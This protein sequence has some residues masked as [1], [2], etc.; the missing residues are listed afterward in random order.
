MAGGG[1]REQMGGRATTP[2][3]ILHSVW[4][5]NAASRWPGGPAA[6]PA[7]CPSCPSFSRFFDSR[8]SPSRPGLVT[9]ERGWIGHG[10]DREMRQRLRDSGNII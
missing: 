4:T 8:R 10:T 6:R 1:A 3:H 2:P 7:R 9:E 5:E